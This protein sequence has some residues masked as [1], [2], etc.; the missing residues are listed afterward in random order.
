MNTKPEGR[1]PRKPKKRNSK[2]SFCLAGI[3]KK[4]TE[5]TDQINKNG[6]GIH[7]GVCTPDKCEGNL[8]VYCRW[9][10]AWDGV[11]YKFPEDV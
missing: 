6:G 4:T 5:T 3:K 7:W 11:L 1:L 8:Y 2:F 10:C 9:T